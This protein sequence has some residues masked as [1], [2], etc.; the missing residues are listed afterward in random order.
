M[1]S[2]GTE[3]GGALLAGDG[4]LELSVPS[5]FYQMCVDDSYFGTSDFKTCGLYFPGLPYMAV[6]TNGHIAWS[7]TYLYADITDWYREEVQLD[8]NGK[9]QATLFQGEWKPLSTHN[10]TFQTRGAMVP[11]KKHL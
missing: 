10:E 6:G 3:G 11:T 7:Q 2:D 4:H 1:T 5:L 9:P 8:A